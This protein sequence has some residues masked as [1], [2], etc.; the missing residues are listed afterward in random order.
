M[1]FNFF[2]W[3]FVRGLLDR[4]SKFERGLLIALALAAS[5]LFVFI[6]TASEV[7]EGE[8]HEF[9]TR[10]LMF[11][12]NPQDLSDPLG[13]RWFEEAM[14]DFTALGGTAVLGTITI[15]VVTFLIISAKKRTALLVAVSILGGVILSNALKW[16]FDRP[17][18]D[19]VP[20]GMEVYTLS[21]PSSHAMMAAVVY[22]T[23]GALL[24]RT[25]TSPRMRI[26]LLSCAVA[27]TMVVGISRVY[28]GVHWPT[29]VIAGWAVGAC[30]AL[31]CWMLALWMQRQGPIEKPGETDTSSI[32][33]KR[34]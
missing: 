33:S 22:L 13:P 29:D 20:H 19:L 4:A 34:G 12:R 7:F 15:F 32:G 16:G 27:L 25:L 3:A 28:L 6:K 14:R 8:S 10:V 5:L 17:R 30:W 1:R 11:F 23:L 31:G 21:F 26:F 9:D 2:S 18:P 24:S